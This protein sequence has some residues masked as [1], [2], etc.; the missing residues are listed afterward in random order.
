MLTAEENDLLTRVGPGKPMGEVFRR[1]WLPA[2]PSDQVSEPDGPPVRLRLLGED[3]V[4][5]RDSDG[6]I[7]LLSA[8]CPHRGASLFFGRNEQCGLRCA[9]HGWKYDR[10]G[11][12]TDLPGE[13]DEAY[14]QRIRIKAYPVREIAGVAWTYMGPP[15]QMGEPPAFEWMRTPPSHRTCSVWLQETNWLQG[16][17]G[18]IDSAHVS[19]L[20][21]SSVTSPNAPMVH[22]PLTALDKKPR[23]LVKHTDYGLMSVARRN[24]PDG[25]YYWRVTQWLLPMYSLVPSADWPVGGRAWV[26]IDDHHTY[27]WDF[28]YLPDKPLPDRYFEVRKDGRSFPPACEPCRFRL[29]DGYVIDTWRPV[30]NRD[31]DYLIDRDLQRSVSYSGIHGVNDQDRAIQDSMGPICD[32]SRE[33][34]IATDGAIIVARRLLKRLAS[35]VQNGRPLLPALNGG[36]YNVRPLDI[37]HPEPDLDRLLESCSQEIRGKIAA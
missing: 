10:E 34:L 7:G 3:L 2:L 32:R 16:A 22:R 25:H 26:P 31:N 20:H 5:F 21:S 14:R 4:A 1:F 30:R 6:K 23:L 12:C 27:C 9:Y 35:D 36:W 29:P 33:N 18:E 11:R 28:T 24:A 19:F 37:V 17:E 8:Y 13:P 15:D